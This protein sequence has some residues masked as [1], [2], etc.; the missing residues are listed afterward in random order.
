[1]R[2]KRREIAAFLAALL[3]FLCL[4]W[5]MGILPRPAR[6]QYGSMWRAYRCE[7]RDSLDVLFFGS[8]L[9]YCDVAPAWVWAESG[10]RG[11]VMAGPEQTIPITYY[12][13]REA[14]RTQSPQLIML[15]VTGMFYQK[16]QSYTRANIDYMPFTANRLGATFAAAERELV[17]ELLYPLFAYH[18]R[19]DTIEREELQSK[20]EPSAVDPLAGYTFLSDACAPPDYAERAEFTAD[21]DTYRENLRWLTRIRDFCDRQG[22]PL[23]LCVAPSAGR[24]PA[25][26]METLRKDVAALGL[27]LTDLN[28]ALPEL[29]IDDTNDWYDFLHF[30]ARGAEKFSRWLGADLVGTQGLTPT[31]GEDTA[32][33]ERLAYLEKLAGEAA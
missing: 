13:I 7:P 1:M 28:E 22:I 12:Y 30:N 26:A 5:G 10:L 23:L 2:S 9:V 17:P 27:T 16:Y 25:A 19:W 8:S 3:L 18:D 24:I 33:A 29:G 31:A 32:W 21:S 11:F 6:L 4:S 15:E 14:C 20:L